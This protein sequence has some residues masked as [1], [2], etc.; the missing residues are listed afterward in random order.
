MEEL[1]DKEKTLQDL[2]RLRQ[3][4]SKENKIRIAGITETTQDA[5]STGVII[6]FCGCVANCPGCQNPEVADLNC[7]TGFSIDFE[8]LKEYLLKL[9]NW[10]DFIIFSGGEPLLQ[11]DAVMAISHWAKE[12]VFDNNKHLDP[13]SLMIYSG[14]EFEEIPEDVKEIMDIIKCGQFEIDKKDSNLK[15]RGSSNQGLF[16]KNLDGKWEQWEQWEP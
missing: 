2:D 8:G 5:P 3:L 10:I 14:Y 13:K 4:Y 1:I 9:T 16:K 12:H 15:F 6:W 7:K 11:K